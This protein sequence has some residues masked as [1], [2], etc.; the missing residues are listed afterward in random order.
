[1]VIEVITNILLSPIRRKYLDFLAQ[2]VLKITLEFLEYFKY[3]VLMFDYINISLSTKIISKCDKVS[4]TM[5]G[6]MSKRTIY[7]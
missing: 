6:D 1:M 3:L 7:I 4:F 2:L 5:S